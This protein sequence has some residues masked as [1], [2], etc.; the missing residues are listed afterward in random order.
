M[1]ISS[2]LG[3]IF[4]GL[5]ISTTIFAWVANMLTKINKHK[6]SAKAIRTAQEDTS[7]SSEGQISGNM[8]NRVIQ[9]DNVELN[10]TQNIEKRLSD[11]ENSLKSLRNTKHELYSHEYSFL[12][13]EFERLINNLKTYV[14]DKHEGLS[15]EQKRY[16]TELDQKLS[17]FQTIFYVALTI[18]GLIVTGFG[19]VV[20]FM[21]KG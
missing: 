6:V 12:L 4:G 10:Y 17:T 3:I 16:E 20:Y 21:G 1:E 13:F 11:I 8:F 9:R 5:G 14:N 2:I 19:V 18:I 7:M 15:N